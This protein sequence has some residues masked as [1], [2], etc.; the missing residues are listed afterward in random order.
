[1]LPNVT[2]ASHPAVTLFIPTCNAGP[3]FPEI[4]GRMQDQRLDRSVEVLIVD[5]GSTDGTVEFLR[6]Q[7]VRLIEIPNSQFNHGLTRNLGIRRKWPGPTADRFH[8]TTPIPL[9]ATVWRVGWPHTR[10]REFSR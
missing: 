2:M 10:R 8:G 5:S 4:L 1:M 6:R 7:P 3:E 9:F